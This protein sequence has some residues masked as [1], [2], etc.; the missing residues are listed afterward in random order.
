L[1]CGEKE[2]LD[3]KTLPLL[4]LIDLEEEKDGSLKLGDLNEEDRRGGF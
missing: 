3:F 1:A 4:E 2:E